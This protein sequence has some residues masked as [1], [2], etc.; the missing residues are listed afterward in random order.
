M[1]LLAQAEASLGQPD[2]VQ[3]VPLR[4]YV[5]DLL[6]DGA[7]RP[8]AAAPIAWLLLVGIRVAGTRGVGLTDTIVVGGVDAGR[9][10]TQFCD[11]AHLR[12]L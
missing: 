10:L 5:E 4:R 7:V 3:S 2:A 12:G 11:F 1:A 6:E 9:R 8:G